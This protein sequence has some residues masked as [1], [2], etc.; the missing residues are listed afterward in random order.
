[1]TLLVSHCGSA[2]LL[3]TG[4]YSIV[5]ARHFAYEQ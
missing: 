3:Q 4:T 5:N 1:M 2:N